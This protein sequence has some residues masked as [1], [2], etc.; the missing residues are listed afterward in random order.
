MATAASRS[1]M[2]RNGSNGASS[3]MRFGVFRAWRS[4][5]VELDHWRPHDPEH[6]RTSRARPVYAP[7]AS[8][9]VIAGA[10]CARAT[11]GRSSRRAR[12]IQRREEKRRL[13]PSA[14][15]ERLLGLP[16]TVRAAPARW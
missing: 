16:R 13:P 3:Q 15:A 8:A 9:M 14:L 5:L 1:G 4:G 6:L 7:S 2:V 12:V 10:E 11:T